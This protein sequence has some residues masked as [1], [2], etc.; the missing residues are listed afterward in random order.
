MQKGFGMAVDKI[1]AGRQSG[2]TLTTSKRKL[3]LLCMAFTLL[4]FVISSD[5]FLM[6]SV[7]ILY[8]LFVIQ[9]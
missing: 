4:T 9:T 5:L 1:D 6:D 7:F 8:L 2:H 3:I